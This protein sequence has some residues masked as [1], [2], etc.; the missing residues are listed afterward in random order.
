MLPIAPL[1]HITLSL[2]ALLRLH[3]SLK[4]T[5]KAFCF[6]F[7]KDWDEGVPLVLFAAQEVVQESLCF[8]PNELVFGYYVTGPLSL[9]RERLLQDNTSKSKDKSVEAR[10]RFSIQIALCL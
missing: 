3:Q 8:S 7:E 4:S 9:L 10:K 1:V 6:E 5:L 2:K